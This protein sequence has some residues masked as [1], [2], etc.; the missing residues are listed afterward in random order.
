MNAAD[1]SDIILQEQFSE[2][3]EQHEQGTFRVNIRVLFRRIPPRITAL[4]TIDYSSN[5]LST[6]EAAN[7]I[8][9]EE[10]NT[11]ADGENRGA[12]ADELTMSV[13][14]FVSDDEVGVEYVIGNHEVRIVPHTQPGLS[15]VPSV[16]F[17][18]DIS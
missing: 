8:I 16:Q 12:A 14:T 17:A 4:I 15:P 3:L 18:A 13:A 1:R 2:I 7:D 11:A 10:V 9:E 6:V 5:L